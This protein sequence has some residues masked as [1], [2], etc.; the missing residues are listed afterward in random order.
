[1]LV[2]RVGHPKPS[3]YRNPYLVGER[4][5][6]IS[7]RKAIRPESPTV[8]RVR[9]LAATGGYR[10]MGALADV[11]G[12]TIQR[13]QQIIR[14]YEIP[15]QGLHVRLRW[16]CP[17]CG[18]PVSVP[19]STWA[20]RWNHLPAHCRKCAKQ[21]RAKFCIRGH[22]RS[23]NTSAFH[24]C[25]ACIRE[26]ARCVI[27]IRI[28]EICHKPLNI[29]RGAR[30]QEQRGHAVG[31]YHRACWISQLGA[32]TGPARRKTHC[33]RGHEFTKENTYHWKGQRQC[34]ECGKRRSLE[35]YYRLRAQA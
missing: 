12:V 19:R 23:E 28:C 16:A 22:L 31:R 33:N 17:G 24:S 5:S 15:W 13:V 1:M 29:S 32:L 8:V 10:T 20:E 14:Q 27:E 4:F 7:R 34:R 21:D 6:R 35:R 30:G 25:L 9:E 3:A 11:V 26:R 2:P 18:D